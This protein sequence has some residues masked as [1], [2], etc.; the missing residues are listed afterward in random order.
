MPLYGVGVRRPLVFRFALL[1]N[2]ILSRHRN[3]G[4]DPDSRLP[5][6]KVISAQEVLSIF[7]LAEAQGMKGGAVWYDAFMAN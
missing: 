3:E 7:P 2:D 4:L 1:L 6:G 5:P